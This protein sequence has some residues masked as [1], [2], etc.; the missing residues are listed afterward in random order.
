MTAEDTDISI[1]KT[2]WSGFS[3]T[4]HHPWVFALWVLLHL[5]LGLGP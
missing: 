5:V 4:S 1:E 2:V 3:L